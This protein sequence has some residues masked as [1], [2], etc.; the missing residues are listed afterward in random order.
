MTFKG[1]RFDPGPERA[2]VGID[3]WKTLA[4]VSIRYEK[5]PCM[6]SNVHDMLRE[7]GIPFYGATAQVSES[8]APVSPKGGA[9]LVL[10]TPTQLGFG[11]RDQYSYL[12]IL[13]VGRSLALLPCR[14]AVGPQMLVQNTG[15]DID[16][17]LVLA[18]EP[19][20]LGWRK[21]S[22]Y[23]F[24]GLGVGYRSLNFK[25]AQRYLEAP[26]LER[27][28]FARRHDL[29]ELEQQWVFELDD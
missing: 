20:L 8:K 23:T 26:I 12:D 24:C 1:R 10:A 21:D 25:P 16:E 28:D 2:R 19:G 18:C 14:P 6:F 22:G 4:F 13:S 11:K 3:V 27:P 29:E 9:T 15:P 5:H 17:E 7:R